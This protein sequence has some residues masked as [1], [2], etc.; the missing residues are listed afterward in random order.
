[1][2]IIPLLVWLVCFE[3]DLEMADHRNQGV[4]DFSRTFFFPAFDPQLHHAEK[5]MGRIGRLIVNP[6]LIQFFRGQM[7]G[8]DCF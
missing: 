1:M 7:W 6:D 4:R 3:R 8:D 5:S 2:T